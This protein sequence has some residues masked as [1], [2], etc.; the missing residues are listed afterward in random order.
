[1]QTFLATKILYSKAKTLF[2]KMNDNKIIWGPGSFC[3]NPTHLPLHCLRHLYRHLKAE[4]SL[5]A[6]YSRAQD[7][8]L[9]Q[10]RTRTNVYTDLYR[11]GPLGYVQCDTHSSPN[12][13]VQE[14]AL[15]VE[16]AFADGMPEGP[17]PWCPKN[18]THRRN[19]FCC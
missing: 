12:R 5:K 8:C 1:M 2:Y 11:S 15:K 6:T 7:L 18:K 4:N 14:T 19:F 10:V 3:M 9:E 16:T 17:V 13:K